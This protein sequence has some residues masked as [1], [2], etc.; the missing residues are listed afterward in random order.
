M[1]FEPIPGLEEL[2]NEFDDFFREEMKNVSSGWTNSPDD[3]ET[4]EGMALTRHMALEL[5]K[6][7]WRCLGWPQKY[8]GLEKSIFEQ[9]VFNEARAYWR[10]PGIDMFGINMLGPTLLAVGTE[11]QRERFLPPIARGEVFWAQLWSEPEAGSDLANCQTFA[12]RDG[13][14]YIVNGQKVWTSRAHHADWSF[15]VVRTSKELTRSRGLSYLCIDMKS[16]GITIRPLPTMSSYG[17]QISHFNEVFLDDVRIPVENL[18]GE[19]NKGWEVIRATMNFERSELDQFA[20]VQRTLRE[21]IKFCRETKWRG[22]PLANDPLVRNRL[23]QVATEVAAGRASARHLL[24]GQHK[25]FTGLESP[26]DQDT[27]SSS[28]KYYLTELEYRLDFIGLQIMGLYGQIKKE[29]RWAPMSGRFESAYQ[30]APGLQLA[31]GSTEIQK[32][33]IAWGG[34]GLP[35]T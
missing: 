31:G 1:D 10:A 34:L 14:H 29:S 4:D 7:G 16:P 6:R 22:E 12:K 30:Y 35:R 13:D 28:I 9:L 19:E 24:W 17:K 33:I 15:A 8:G 27:R 23:A 2:K 18:V 26:R 3:R 21:L 11:E 32:N 25:L 20:E 5:G